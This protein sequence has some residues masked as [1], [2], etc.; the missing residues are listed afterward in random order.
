MEL[1]KKL[2]PEMLARQPEIIKRKVALRNELNNQQKAL[3]GMFQNQ[4][5]GASVVSEK[6]LKDF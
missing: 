2:N 6:T 4:F 5:R 1:L 3:V